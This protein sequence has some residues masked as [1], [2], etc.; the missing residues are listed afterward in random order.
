MPWNPYGRR[1]KTEEAPDIGDVWAVLRQI[2][3][4]IGG[5]SSEI[6]NIALSVNRYDARIE[7]VA[8]ELNKAVGRVEAVASA[9]AELASAA[10]R[11]PIWDER[12]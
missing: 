12:R 11:P 9:L 7:A 3:N 4:I 6:A 8:V 5:M 1:R 10:D 2:Q